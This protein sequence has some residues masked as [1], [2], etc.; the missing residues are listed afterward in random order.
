MNQT[1]VFIDW[2]VIHQRHGEGLPVVSGGVR[3]R[4]QEIVSQRDED[5][6]FYLVKAGEKDGFSVT[7][8]RVKGSHDT[9]VL[10]L[11]DGAKVTTS[12]NVGRYG[13]P[14]NIWNLDLAQTVAKASELA[15]AEG[16]PAYHAGKHEFKTQVSERDFKLGLLQEWTG[17][18]FTQLHVTQNL[19]TG[20]DEL[21]RE[22]MRWINGKRAA[23]LSKGRYGDES[24]QFGELGKKNK[25]LHKAL[26]VYRKGPELLAHARGEEAKARI[27]QSD[28]YQY[29]MD[30]GLVRI[31][32]KWGSHFLRDNGIRYM[33]DADMAKVVSIFSRETEFLRDS[34]P[35]RSARLVDKMPTKLKGWALH[36]IMGQD[37]A[38]LMPRSTYYRVC[39]ALRDY[40]IDASEPRCVM[41]RPDAEQ[42][43]NR[44]LAALP[45]FEL[46]VAHEPAW[47]DSA[48]WQ[49]AA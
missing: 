40:G 19:L 41:G 45:A 24:I 38:C 7:S 34:T 8:K 20:S 42:A 26:V 5:G 37:L 18:Y 6:L 39:K 43:L 23:R 15:A 33:G 35:D 4:G 25:P 13:R 17:A 22:W 28:A 21:G 9:Q 32:C 29:A 31:E 44:M 27:K 10:T 16:L 2:M 12:G 36:W 48:E 46:R 11:C 3:C 49:R 14:D 30:N 47:Y 1:G